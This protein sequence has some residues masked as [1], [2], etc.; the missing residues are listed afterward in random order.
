M[1]MPHI[2]MPHGGSA[3]GE[4]ALPNV[5]IDSVPAPGD[6]T[7]IG[8][9]EF[10][11]GGE[12][13]VLQASVPIKSSVIARAGRLALA[14]GTG[15]YRVRQILGRI[16]AAL[17]VDCRADVTLMSID[18][19]VTDGSKLFTEVVSLSKTGVNT[20]RI[21]R[22]EGF[23]CN[24]ES[25]AQGLTVA[26][27]HEMLDEIE[28]CRGR[29]SALQSG[30]ASALACGAFVFLLGGGL[31]EMFCAAVGAGVGQWLR[32]SMLERH[33]NQFAT[34]MAA[35]AVAC[36]L[37]LLVLSLLEL[38]SPG[39]AALHQ[40]GYIGAMLFVIPGFPLITSGLDIAKMDLASGIERLVYAACVIGVAT[41]AAWCVAK[42]TTLYPADL[43]RADLAL[44]LLAALRCIASFVGV[45][46]FSV[47]FNSTPRMAATAGC[48]GAL[49]NTA[50]LEL[51]D[52]AS[53]PPEAAALTGA[54]I[55][56]L[57]ASVVG[58]RVRVPRIS[59][60]VPS[61]VIM[62]PGLYLYEAMYYMCD[63]DVVTAMGWGMRAVVVIVCLPIGLALARVLT[64]KNWRYDT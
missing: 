2:P 21:W 7:T 26:E 28:S 48:I 34:T 29:Y 59:L 52:L 18:L 39:M 3:P 17:G 51:V 22:I 45:F 57:L 8:W 49:A 31:V 64:D 10:V 12:T 6:P 24:L 16:S 9:H 63:F 41:L 50:R 32:K 44:P 53:M 19:T 43:V 23:V 38:A 13:P 40:A 4:P 55:A 47:L 46:G 27:V 33:I 56:G 20:E 61:I 37:Y 14:S 36:L 35:V 60:T 11:D 42:L 25:Y 15:G 5:T 62:V 1:H 30:I 54:L 58:P